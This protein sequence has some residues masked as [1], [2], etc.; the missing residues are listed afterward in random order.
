MNKLQKFIRLKI[1]SYLDWK[2]LL[3][4][5]S[6]LSAN[7]RIDLLKSK[8]LG[9]HCFEL[10]ISQQNVHSMPTRMIYPFL[11]ASHLKLT[12]QLHQSVEYEE[13]ESDVVEFIERIIYAT[14]GLMKPSEVKELQYKNVSTALMNQSE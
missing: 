9:E 13:N 10:K 14:Q 11:L 7:E 4:K 1:Y 6:K 12:I 5:I 3:L 8:L 2:T